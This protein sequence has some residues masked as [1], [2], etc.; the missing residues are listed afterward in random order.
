MSKRLH[1]D[2]S[3][4]GENIRRARF[5]QNLTQGELAA[6]SELAV[7]TIHHAEEGRPLV[8]RTLE[9]ICASLNCGIDHIISRQ[10]T[11]LTDA[12]DLLVHRAEEG[13]WNALGDR[14]AKIPDDNLERIQSPEERTRLG[15]LGLVTM[16]TYALTFILPEGPGTLHLE[17][18]GANE[19]TINEK[20]YR[21]CVLLCEGGEAELT[22]VG[23]SVRLREGDAAA[24]RTAELVRLSASP[25][26]PARL[27]WIGSG[28]L[29]KLPRG[30]D[31]T[32]IRRQ[33]KS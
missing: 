20:I 4:V 17:L 22:V 32:R 9:K 15:S 21:E 1:L 3:V 12:V 14:R 24:F 16:F 23:R 27:T 13:V 19:G 18:Y 7:A 33:R 28:R 5:L 6:L 29:G 30:K 25:E 11:H 31:R 10:R 8:P 2:W 26:R